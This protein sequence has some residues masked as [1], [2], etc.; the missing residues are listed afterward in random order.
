MDCILSSLASQP[1]GN[2]KVSPS[3]VYL[4]KVLT[5]VSAISISLLF[6]AVAIWVPGGKEIEASLGCRILD[7][8]GITKAMSIIRASRQGGIRAHWRIF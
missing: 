6:G 3:S 4:L 1:A 2:V 7:F 5:V 8:I